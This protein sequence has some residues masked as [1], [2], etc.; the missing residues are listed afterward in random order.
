MTRHN[1]FSSQ[2]AAAVV[3]TAIVL[4]GVTACSKPE[5]RSLERNAPTDGK[6]KAISDTISFHLPCL[7]SLYTC[8]CRK[9][10]DTA[11]PVP[12]KYR[13]YRLIDSSI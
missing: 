5:N 1:V 6:G 4:G 11:C 13:S 2:V 8:L 3:A 7:R 12:D 9:Y 10:P